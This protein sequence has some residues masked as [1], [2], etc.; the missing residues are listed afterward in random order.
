[1]RD[2]FART[3]LAAATVGLIAFAVAAGDAGVGNAGM[4]LGTAAWSSRLTADQ[5]RVL[6]PNARQR[7]IVLLRDQHP[8]LAG[9]LPRQAHAFATDRA[10]I[11]SQLRQLRVPR[12]VT[13]RTVNAIAASVS[14][15][16]AANLRRD[17]AVLAV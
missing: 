8:A 17:P 12:L 3:V 6:S 4:P 13:Y 5:V 14:A 7:V 16:E 11:V 1:M 15:A 10:P 9:R 2:M